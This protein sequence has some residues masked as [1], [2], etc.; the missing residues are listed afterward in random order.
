VGDVEHSRFWGKGWL[1]SAAIILGLG[2][3]LAILG[4]Y[5]S[6]NFGWPWVWLYWTGLIA[7][8]GSVG[9]L[10]GPLL[11]R[12][13]PGFPEWT[14]Y[15]AAIL[16]VSVPVTIAVLAL[17]TDFYARRPSLSLVVE[18]YF[19]VCVIS[20]FVTA[21][22]WVAE[23]LSASRHAAATAD[24]PVQ[25]GAAL[26]D[27][28]PHGLRKAA[29]LSMT[30]EDHYLRVRTEAGEALILMRLS[31]A[32][33][34]CEGLDGARTHRSWWVARDAVADAQ[35]GDGRGTLILSDGTEA[36][37]S[38]TYYPKLREAGWF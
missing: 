24:A 1:R 26:V 4:P 18:V 13:M 38:R 6:S 32:V 8:G 19:L 14:I 30:A 9:F 22:T 12:L 17:S 5:G 11:P 7:L 20:T 28:L 3:F 34:A 33:A 15:V 25:A 35:K 23:R 10:T 21:V 29:I 27:K 31:D 2:S 36:P 16:L 37:V